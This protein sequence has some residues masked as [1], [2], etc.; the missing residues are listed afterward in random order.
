[1][2]RALQCLATL[3]LI[4]IN[5]KVFA[6]EP[7][8]PYVGVG[9]GSLQHRA[10]ASYSVADNGLGEFASFETSN[11]SNQYFNL[12]A[13]FNI[14]SWFAVELQYGA[15]QSNKWLS[16]YMEVTTSTAGLFAVLQKG[17]DLYGRFRLGLAQRDIDISGSEEF[18]FDNQTELNG[19]IGLSI[20]QVLP[21]GQ[22]EIMYMYYPKM[23][24]E[25]KLLEQQTD[26]NPLDDIDGILADDRWVSQTWAIA[27]IYNF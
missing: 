7:L 5:T 1:M 2:K 12:I 18:E 10:E 27:Y 22:V 26:L 9:I 25:S 20:G 14:Y 4:A 21:V 24:I 8:T 23:K 6:A 11:P 3:L 13:G 16:E 15:T 17:D 19:A